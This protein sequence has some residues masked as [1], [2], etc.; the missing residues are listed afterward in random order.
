MASKKELEVKTFMLL[1]IQLINQQAKKC[2]VYPTFDEMLNLGHKS[3][4]SFM[5]DKL[6]EKDEKTNP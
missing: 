1:T 2:S 6:K 5:V 3:T 4:I